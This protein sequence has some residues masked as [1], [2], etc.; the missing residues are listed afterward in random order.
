MRRRFGGVILALVCTLAPLRGWAQNQEREQEPVR[1]KAD[2][3]TYDEQRNT[4]TAIGDVVVTKGETTVTADT[5]G[6]NRTT[7]EVEA[8]GNVV[9]KDPRGQI[10]A[11][12]LRLEMQDETGEITNGT[13]HLPR[14]QYILTGKTLQKSYGQTYHIENGAFTTCLCDD[15]RKADWSISGETIDVTLHGKGEVHNGGFRVRL[16]LLLELA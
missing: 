8:R 10:E 6:V 3:L 7:S 1:V 9:V 15:F 16:T 12:A 4:V 2:S 14:N 13:V 5:V 11:E